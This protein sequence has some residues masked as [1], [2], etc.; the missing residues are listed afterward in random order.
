[1]PSFNPYASSYYSVGGV[2]AAPRFCGR[3]WFGFTLQAILVRPGNEFK[4]LTGVPVV[5]KTSRDCLRG[6]EER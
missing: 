3:T 4:L 1:M 2:G 6:M 5:T